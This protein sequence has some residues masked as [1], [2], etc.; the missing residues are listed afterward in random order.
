MLVK[1]MRLVSAPV[2]RRVG[3]PLSAL[4]RGAAYSAVVG[5]RAMRMRTGG[6]GIPWPG[7]RGYIVES[8]RDHVTSGRRYNV[9]SPT[10]QD[11]LLIQ[12]FKCILTFTTF[13]SPVTPPPPSPDRQSASHSACKHAPSRFENKK[14]PGYCRDFSLSTP[15]QCSV[16]PSL[17]GAG[18][19]EVTAAS[20]SL[21]SALSP[22]A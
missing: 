5:G 14:N 19:M 2:I 12:P 4:V 22:D 10:T 16:G 6:I 13:C 18:P 9:K 20:L 17:A 3:S 15:S 8:R 21:S 1:D 11:L 7:R